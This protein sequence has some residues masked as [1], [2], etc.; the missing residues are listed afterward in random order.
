VPSPTISIEGVSK[1]F[2]GVRALNR[3]NRLTV[4]RNIFIGREPRRAFG[5]QEVKKR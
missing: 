5:R 2:P 4:A 1:T 3:L